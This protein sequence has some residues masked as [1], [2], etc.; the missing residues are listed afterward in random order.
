MTMTFLSHFS[1]LRGLSIL[2]NYIYQT[3]KGQRRQRR[4]TLI[5]LKP[6]EDW[7]SWWRDLATRSVFRLQAHPNCLWCGAFILTSHTLK[8]V[9]SFL[10]Y[11]PS[12]TNCAMKERKMLL[13]QLIK[14]TKIKWEKKCASVCQWNEFKCPVSTNFPSLQKK[15]RFHQ[16]SFCYNALQNW[17]FVYEIWISLQ[18]SHHHAKLI[19]FIFCTSSWSRCSAKQAA[20]APGCSVRSQEINPASLCGSTFFLFPP[21]LEE[22]V[23]LSFTVQAFSITQNLLLTLKGD[24][25]C[26]CVF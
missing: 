8:T 4:S 1:D 10:F 24:C 9:P 17:L 22:T 12:N 26:K 20:G 19:L 14:E 18:R 21:F 7:H 13:K 5:T 11:R 23:S 16:N 15:K 25:V 3:S 6:E 2:S